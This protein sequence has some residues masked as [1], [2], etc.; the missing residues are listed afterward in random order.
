MSKRLL[1]PSFNEWLT[2][3]TNSVY[4]L[5]RKRISKKD[6]MFLRRAY[7]INVIREELQ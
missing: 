2:N 1:N 3:I 5:Q 6:K 7:E 4:L